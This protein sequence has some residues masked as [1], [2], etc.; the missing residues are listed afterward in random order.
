MHYYLYAANSTTDNDNFVHQIAYH[1]FPR[2]SPCAYNGEKA[3]SGWV[4]GLYCGILKY[5]DSK[6]GFLSN[7]GMG[8]NV[9]VDL[10]SDAYSIYILIC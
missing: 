10:F 8:H 2:V 1:T 9:S 5:L 4:G 7:G 6:S 3:K